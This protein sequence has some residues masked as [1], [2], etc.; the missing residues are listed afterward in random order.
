MKNSLILALYLTPLALAGNFSVPF[1]VEPTKLVRKVELSARVEPKI[2]ASVK[3]RWYALIKKLGTVLNQTVK[4]GDLLAEVSL[5]YLDYRI[6]YFASRM[7]FVK[8]A[9]ADA[10]QE[11]AL[12]AQH[13]QKVTGL[14]QKGIVAAQDLEKLE[15][16]G[17]DAAL[18]K[19]RADKE[20]ANLRKQLDETNAQIK[21]ANYY[22]PIGGVITEMMVNPK[23]VSGVVI[24]MPDVK[25]V[26]IDQPGV[27]RAMSVALDTQAV[28]LVPG[29]KG[30][31]IFEA[32]GEM[33]NA[34][35]TQITENTTASK[36]GVQ[37]FDV[38]LEFS[39]PGPIIARGYAVRVEIPYGEERT[40]PAIPWNALRDTDSPSVLKYEKAN[41]WV[42]AKVRLGVRGRHRVEVVE[43][44]KV[45]DIVNADLW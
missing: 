34:A 39:K 33:I 23:Q 6:T 9:A 28:H 36:N 19:I 14:V 7:G 8:S 2:S 32:T 42:E 27:Y 25:L 10:A 17:V 30:S 13:K 44:L 37:L 18:K 4:E 16:Q 31:V 45:G 38:Q 35:V 43:G 11:V 26:R 21:D 20:V 40:V 12:L 22:A 29:M 1:T 15:V 5:E 3:I 24:A 41:G